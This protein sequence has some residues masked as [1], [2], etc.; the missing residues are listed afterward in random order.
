M[1]ALRRAS[2]LTKVVFLGTIVALLMA[3]T[4]AFFAEPHVR[5]EF[6]DFPDGCLTIFRRDAY[7]TSNLIWWAGLPVAALALMAEF[8]DRHSHTVRAGWL[9]LTV[10]IFVAAG[11]LTPIRWHGAITYD[12]YGVVSV[13]SG[14][15]LSALGGLLLSI[16]ILVQYT[17]PE[18]FRFVTSRHAVKRLGE[19][20][21]P[22]EDHVRLNRLP[23]QKP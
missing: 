6:C 7:Q 13:L 15:Y 19:S 3:L 9:G 8:A 18:I 12:D 1:G 16:F 14:Q 4:H 20:G 10:G 21:D 11:Y 17:L 22:G 23:V 2:L 5:S